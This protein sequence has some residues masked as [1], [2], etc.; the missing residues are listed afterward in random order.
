MTR[1]SKGSAAAAHV[2][3]AFAAGLLA[4]WVVPLNAQD[5][6]LAGQLA[7]MRAEIATLRGEIA[8]LDQQVGLNTPDFSAGTPTTRRIAIQSRYGSITLDRNGIALSSDTIRINGK[9][10]AV[11]ATRSLD[12]RGGAI[13]MVGD[14]ITSKAARDKIIKGSSVGEN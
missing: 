9:V 5:G 8:L 11:G 1:V 7:Q 6:A 2:A 13:T 3:L 12:L 4:A 10:L 14:T